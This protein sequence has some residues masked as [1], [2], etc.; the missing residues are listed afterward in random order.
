MKGKIAQRAFYDQVKPILKQAMDE[1]YQL[2]GRRYDLV[3][4]YR[5][6]DAEYAI[7]CMGGMAETAEVTCNYLRE[8]K[9]LKVGVVHVTS[10]RP[11][12]GPELV[13][14]LAHTKAIA[15]VERMD[16]PMGQSNPLTAELKAAFADALVG[17]PDYPRVHRMPLIYSGSAGLGSRDIRPGDFIAVVDNMINQGPRYFVLGIKHLLALP[18]TNDPDVRPAG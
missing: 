3:E 4:P 8:H 2:T 17:T 12:P 18:N 10:F 16:N 15:V 6:D 13:Q 7:V 11:F 5:M 1:F 9:G 14:I